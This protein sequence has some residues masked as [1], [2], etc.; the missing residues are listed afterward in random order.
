MANKYYKKEDDISDEEKKYREASELAAS[1]ECVLRFEW[2]VKSLEDAAKIFRSIGEYKDAKEQ[3]ELCEKK[4]KEALFKGYDEVY[5][6][7]LL[8]QEKAENKSDYLDAVSD[9][10]RVLKSE[11]YETDAKEHISVCRKAILRIETKAAWKKRGIAF[12]VLCILL[13]LFYKSPA[14]SFVRGYMLQVQ[15][16]YHTALKRYQNAAGFP[17]T[18]RQCQKCYLEIGK[19]TL[20]KGKKKKALREL[21]KAGA[22]KEAQEL[23]AGLEKEFL[24]EAETGQ[25]LRFGMLRWKVLKKEAGSVFLICQKKGTKHLYYKKENAGFYQSHIR[26]WLNGSYKKAR[27]SS[28]ERALMAETGSG[29]SNDGQ[30][31][32][33][34]YQ[35]S[36][37]SEEEYLMYKNLLQ[38]VKHS[39]WLKDERRAGNMIRCVQADGETGEADGAEKACFVRPVICVKTE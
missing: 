16:K 1:V 30:K 22:E 18:D 3:A 6:R 9:F 12:C 34:T 23:V 14:Y 4:A 17:L 11:R 21:R 7:A 31:K 25:I 36:L 37:L 38:P 32:I 15:G 8:K 19:K 35:V 5:Q 39:F 28:Y 10:K 13:I 26:K 27:F 20:A 33:R 29:V 2:R 24:K